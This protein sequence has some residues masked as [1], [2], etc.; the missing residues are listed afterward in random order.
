M[1][2]KTVL[3][4]HQGTSEYSIGHVRGPVPVWLKCW[5]AEFLLPV[6]PQGDMLFMRRDPEWPSGSGK[7]GLLSLDVAA[8]VLGWGQC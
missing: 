2:T 7:V 3:I 6:Y 4:K 1:R 8:I 5:V